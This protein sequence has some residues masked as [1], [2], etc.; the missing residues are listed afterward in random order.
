MDVRHG[1]CRRPIYPQYSETPQRQSDPIGIQSVHFSMQDT[2]WCP[3]SGSCDC[4][5]SVPSPVHS[6]AGEEHLSLGRVFFAPV[7]W[8]VGH[9]LTRTNLFRTSENGRQAH[10]VRNICARV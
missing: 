6:R 9:C 10:V 4:L 5:L 8:T 1:L 2:G 3:L 7:E